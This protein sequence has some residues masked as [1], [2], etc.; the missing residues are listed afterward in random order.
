MDISV[1]TSRSIIVGSG[2]VR[3]DS[4][5][6][7]KID[8]HTI[9]KVRKKQRMIKMIMSLKRRDFNTDGNAVAVI[10]FIIQ[11]V[12]LETISGRR[13]LCKL[14]LFFDIRLL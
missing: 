3:C 14:S 4:N 6:A 10:L 13:L 5:L 12:K 9:K 11:Q 2:T 1:D 8:H 7:L